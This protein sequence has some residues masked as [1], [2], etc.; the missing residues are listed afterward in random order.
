MGAHSAKEGATMRSR[1]ATANNTKAESPAR[2]IKGTR[3]CNQQAGTAWIIEDPDPRRHPGTDPNRWE[4]YDFAPGCRSRSQLRTKKDALREAKRRALYAVASG[5]RFRYRIRNVITGTVK[6]VNIKVK[7]T[8]S[9][10]PAIHEGIEFERNL[11]E[12]RFYVFAERAGCL[13]HETEGQCL[14]DQRN[15]LQR[16]VWSFIDVPASRNSGWY[17]SKPQVSFCD[18]RVAGYATL[19]GA[20]EAVEWLDR[21]KVPAN[22]LDDKT[23]RLIRYEVII[24][25][26][27]MLG[28]I[29]KNGLRIKAV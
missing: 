19:R 18:Q 21:H 8:T 9:P 28:S 29:S 6:R 1:T 14:K 11:K 15:C 7:V 10:S 13:R 27:R 22:I 24:G 4:S 3:E 5:V 20:V 26:G 2:K 23:G 25:Q 12:E 17:S 16:P